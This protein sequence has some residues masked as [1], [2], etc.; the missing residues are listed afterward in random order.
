M[1]TIPLGTNDLESASQDVVRIK[2]RNMYLIEN[3]SSIDGF[4]R[5][6]RPTVRGVYN[7]GTGPIMGIWRAD[8]C[9]D[10]ATLV[11]SGQDLFRWDLGATANNIGTVPGTG[12]VSFAG[13]TDRA[14]VL[15]DQQ[16]YFTD[17]ITLTYVPM[18][19]N[20]PVGSIAY[21]DGLF[22]LSISG[23][24]LFYWIQPEETYPDPLNFAS[25]ERFPDNLISIAITS[26]EIW[27][28]GED[29]EEV[30]QYTGDEGAPMSRISGR[31]YSNG[32]LN[33]DCVVSTTKNGLPCLLWVTGTGTVMMAQ[34][35][36][37][38][39][40]N[41]SVDE[42][43]R[44]ATNVRAWPFSYNRHSFYILSADQFTV[45]LDLD[46][47]T[48]S[49]WDSFGYSYW[50]AHLGTQKGPTVYAGDYL[51]NSISFAE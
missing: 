26:D 51:S 38:K 27:M 50:R 34:G 44:T 2:S 36:P 49:R 39:V 3:P 5:V 20:R 12:Y 31:A 21:M 16:V 4:S 28:L 37:A 42:L 9:L 43:L 46:T 13:S 22:L 32:C 11:V 33:K 25:A 35:M 40:S 24:E 45:A 17:G 23:E 10:G 41:E 6:S 47:G 30:W 1:V 18:P 15:R 8:G 29:N 14:L 7:L 48:W 19:D